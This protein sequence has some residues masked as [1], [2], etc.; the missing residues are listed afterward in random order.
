MAEFREQFVQ[1][2]FRSFLDL[3]VL[4]IVQEEPTWGYRIIKHVEENFGIK[5]RH[6][7][8]YPLLRKLEKKSLMQSRIEAKTGRTR[9]IYEITPQGRLLLRAFNSFLREHTQDEIST[10]AASS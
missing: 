6:A 9:K 4:R 3:M 2:M 8:L 7:A 5:L 1:R 10:S